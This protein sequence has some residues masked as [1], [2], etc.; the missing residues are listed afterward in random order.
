MR[1]CQIAT[2]KK[3]VANCKL[4]IANWGALESIRKRR[5]CYNV[6]WLTRE[7]APDSTNRSTPIPTNREQAIR[8]REKARELNERWGVGAKQYRYRETRD[9]YMWLERFPGA[10]FDPNGY[11]RFATKKDYLSAGMKIGKENCLRPGIAALPSYVQ[12]RDNG[13]WAQRRL[14]ILRALEGFGGQADT[15][16]VLQA[17]SKAAVFTNKGPREEDAKPPEY[18]FRQALR[19]LLDWECVECSAGRLYLTNAGRGLLAGTVTA[20]PKAGTDKTPT[21]RLWEVIQQVLPSDRWT[22]LS[23]LYRV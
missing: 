12:V 17:V 19:K 16:T 8:N 6:T 1:R 15:N 23:D 21:T 3:A 9:W 18:Y 22:R 10:Y 2:W 7:N 11:I 13:L 14:G 4:Q 20:A 5:N